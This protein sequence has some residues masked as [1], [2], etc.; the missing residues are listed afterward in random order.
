[1]DEEGEE[2]VDEQEE[3]MGRRRKR[4]CGRCKGQERSEE[5]PTVRSKG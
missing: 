1:M 2:K 3:E 5:E 4:W